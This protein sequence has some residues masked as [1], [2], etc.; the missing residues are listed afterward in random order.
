M[1]VYVLKSEGEFCGVFSSIEKA[2]NY[3]LKEYN[4]VAT[5]FDEDEGVLTMDTYGYGE[6]KFTSED[7]FTISN[8]KNSTSYEIEDCPLDWED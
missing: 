6:S 4:E 2:K 5:E 7:C 3:A 8:S 1:R